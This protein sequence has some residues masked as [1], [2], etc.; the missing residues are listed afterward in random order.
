MSYRLVDP[1]SM[2]DEVR[3]RD[4]VTRLQGQTHLYGWSRL[5][6]YSKVIDFI[7]D[8]MG[9]NDAYIVGDC[10]LLLVGTVEAWHGNEVALE[11]RLVLC[12]TTGRLSS[13]PCALEGIAKERGVDCI[14]ASDSSINQRMGNLYKRAG[15][16]SITTTYYK[17]V[18]HGSVD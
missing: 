10:Y 4:A 13:V 16:R 6:S 18:N 17:E 7:V 11:E 14:L 15:Y 8:H 5:P 12:L 1:C 2:L 9:N 3:I